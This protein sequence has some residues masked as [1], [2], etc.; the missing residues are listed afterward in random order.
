MSE[1]GLRFLG[2]GNSHAVALG[3][4]AAVLE[5]GTAPWLLIDCGP[6]SLGAYVAHYASLPEAVFITHAAVSQ[7]MRTLEAELGI[8]LFDRSHRTPELTPLGRAVVV[9]HPGEA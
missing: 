6:D 3:S 5:A 2:V 4:S 8:Q 7:Q 1:F 9:R